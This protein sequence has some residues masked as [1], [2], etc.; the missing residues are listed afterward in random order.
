MILLKEFSR[1]YIA[2]QS[3]DW[4]I[5]FKVILM[6]CGQQMTQFLWRRLYMIER[7]ER[8]H[9][10][11]LLYD[12]SRPNLANIFILPTWR[13]SHTN[14]RPIVSSLG[15]QSTWQLHDRRQADSFTSGD[16]HVYR[17]TNL[18]LIFEELILNCSSSSDSRDLHSTKSTLLST[19]H[20]TFI[21]SL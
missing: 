8:H 11:T 13:D 14:N 2:L 3:E 17:C 9:V 20:T 10:K 1:G 5:A 19:A 7:K 15:S 18:C 12:R 6:W 4:C 16:G 21:G